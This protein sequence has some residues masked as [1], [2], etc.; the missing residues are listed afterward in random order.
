MQLHLNA[1]ELN[2]L[3]DTLL[4][5]VGTMSAQKAFGC[6]RSRER[7][8]VAKPFGAMTFYWIRSW[9]RTCDSTQMRSNKWLICWRLRDLTFRTRLRICRIP[10]LRLTLQDKL[11]LVERVLERIDEVRATV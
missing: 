6:R 9:P 1:D 7:G 5:R 4:E 2:L 3:A 8:L 11:G 10:P